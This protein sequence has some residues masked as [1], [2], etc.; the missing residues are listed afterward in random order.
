LK[1]IT[2]YGAI[3]EKSNIFS[4]GAYDSTNIANFTKFIEVLKKDEVTLK[5]SIIVMDNH[6][7]HQSHHIKDILIQEGVELLYLPPYC[8]ELN[9]I[10]K[11]WAYAKHYWKKEMM[12][13][14]GDINEN[15]M[16]VLVDVI[17]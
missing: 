3:T 6:S 5:Q 9:P 16:R 4:Y 1:N 15:D 2:L 14:R 12:D 11:M 10:E 8:S 17:C 7:S 13:F